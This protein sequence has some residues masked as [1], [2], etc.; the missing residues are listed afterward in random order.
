MLKTKK[1]SKTREW[2]Q[3]FYMRASFWLC[4]KTWGLWFVH[5]RGWRRKQSL[6]STHAVSW[7]TSWRR[8]RRKLKRCKWFHTSTHT[9][10]SLLQHS[11]ITAVLILIQVW[12]W[13]FILV[14]ICYSCYE[15]LYDAININTHLSIKALQHCL[16]FSWLNHPLH[17][18]VI[19]YNLK[20]LRSRSRCECY[21]FVPRA[22]WYRTF[23]HIGQ[24]QCILGVV[25]EQ[26]LWS[27]CESQ[28]SWQRAHPC[29]ESHLSLHPRG[30]VLEWD[31]GTVGAIWV[32]W[33]HWY[34]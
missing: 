3:W 18:K 1:S 5:W 16:S 17:T 11:P 33:T 10:L 27:C 22:I 13:P 12:I 7:G 30:A 23:N 25:P 6:C 26:F 31:L 14:K 20:T 32:Q 9:Y 24:C 2:Y 15:H 4:R 8:K 29:W 34:I 19:T 21:H 28:L